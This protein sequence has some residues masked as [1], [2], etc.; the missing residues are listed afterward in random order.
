VKRIA[1]ESGNERNIKNSKK[2][3]VAYCSV[4]TEQQAILKSEWLTT[5]NIYFLVPRSVG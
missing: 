5:T 2:M 3:R 1:P 4:F